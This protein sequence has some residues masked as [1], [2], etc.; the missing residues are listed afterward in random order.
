[1]QSSQTTC[2]VGLTR[3]YLRDVNDAAEGTAVGEDWAE[4]VSLAREAAGWSRPELADRAGICTRTIANVER[5][6]HVPTPP[7]R[8]AIARALGRDVTDLFP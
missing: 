1:M 2:T 6:E 3:D 7:T 8:G 4:R 5:C